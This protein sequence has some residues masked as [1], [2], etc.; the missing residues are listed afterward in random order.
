MKV[1]DFLDIV[2]GE[3]KYKTI[4]KEI[5]MEL[6]SHI[7]ELTEEYESLYGKNARDMAVKAMG[8]P[9]ELGRKI[10]KQYRMPLNWKFGLVFWAAINTA[11]GFAVYPFLVNIYSVRINSILYAVMVIAAYCLINVFYLRRT[12]FKISFRD[13]RDIAA[14][15]IIGSAFSL[16]YLLIMSNLWSFGYYPY[17]ARCAIPY[18]WE[19]PFGIPLY[20]FLFWILWVV[21]M[22]STGK[23]NGKIGI[24]PLGFIWKSYN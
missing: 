13:W 23:P 1:H 9:R 20:F 19:M 14:G 18:R 4:H 15:T 6:Q 22:F 17:G 21:Y 5:R 7:D 8:N 10:N 11:V 3:I 2:C 24:K 16:S 12:H